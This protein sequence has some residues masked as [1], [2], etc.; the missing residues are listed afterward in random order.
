MSPYYF[1]RTLVFQWSDFSS[2]ST[3]KP[4]LLFHWFPAVDLNVYFTATYTTLSSIIGCIF[5]KSLTDLYHCDNTKAQ[6]FQIAFTF[7][8]KT[9]PCLG[10]SRHFVGQEVELWCI[11]FQNDLQ[12]KQGSVYLMFL[13]RLLVG[14]V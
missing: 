12:K 3:S 6:H 9:L 11:F 10:T 1:V 13:S 4:I 8:C 14:I 5:Y 2:L 7:F